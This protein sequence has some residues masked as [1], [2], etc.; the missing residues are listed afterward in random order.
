MSQ[1]L[2]VQC[3]NVSRDGFGLDR[4]PLESVPSASGVTHPL[5]WRR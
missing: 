1:L 2:R 3:F 4:F 5:F